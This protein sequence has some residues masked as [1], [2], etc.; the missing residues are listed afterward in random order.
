MKRP[1]IFLKFVEAVKADDFD[2]LEKVVQDN[3]VDVE[4]EVKQTVGDVIKVPDTWSLILDCYFA[5]EE[6]VT[7]RK[8]LTKLI[9]FPIF[10]EEMASLKL[11]IKNYKKAENDVRYAMVDGYV[12]AQ[13]I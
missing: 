7:A 5:E 6:P 4:K 11:F 13:H 10:D 1:D 2:L 12:N 8:L 3:K 9:F